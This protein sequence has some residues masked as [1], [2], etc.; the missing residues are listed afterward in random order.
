[1]RSASISNTKIQHLTSSP[2]GRLTED[3]RRTESSLELVST[4]H[5]FCCTYT[6][7]KRRAFKKNL[8]RRDQRVFSYFAYDERCAVGSVLPLWFCQRPHPRPHHWTCILIRQDQVTHKIRLSYSFC[9]SIYSLVVYHFRGTSSSFSYSFSSN[10]HLVLR[11]LTQISLSTLCTS[12]ATE[13]VSFS[14]ST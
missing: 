12:P 4:F 9:F 7:L 10:T 1:M 5:L 13:A 6:S 8:F 14:S 2:P 3:N 11:G